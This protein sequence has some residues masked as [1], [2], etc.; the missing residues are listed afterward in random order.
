MRGCA[1][2]FLFAAPLAAGLIALAA[3][4]ARAEKLVTSVSSHR[5]LITSNF[6]GTELVLFGTIEEAPANAQI[7]KYDIVITVRGPARSYVT[8][9]KERVLG[10]WVNAESRDFTRVPSY[11]AVMTNRPPVEMGPPDFLHKNRIGLANHIFAQQIGPD[12]ADVTH[13]DPFRAA[14]LRVKE[15]EGAYITNTSGVTFLTP[16]LFRAAVPI[17]GTALTG[18]YEIE[19]LLLANS[20]VLA[21]QQ[22]AFE[23]VKTGFEAFVA[24]EA[25][26]HGLYYGLAVAFLAI[27]AG[28]IAN[29]LF[30]R[31]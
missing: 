17:L 26:R 4:P 7:G 24:R 3:S 25:R 2:K 1:K 11:L 30:R 18:N 22:T 19:T 13:D 8:R 28:L 16:R 12:I 9:E 23:V 14:F 20:T 29:L 27:V 31:E 15:D 6:T 5:V 10:L 21:K